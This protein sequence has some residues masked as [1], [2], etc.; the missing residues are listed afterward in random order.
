MLAPL[1]T[2]QL[3]L[4][5]ELTIATIPA[6][7]KWYHC[8]RKREFMPT[9]RLSA[10][11][12]IALKQSLVVLGHLLPSEVVKWN[13]TLDGDWEFDPAIFFWITLSDEASTKERLE[14]VAEGIIEIINQNLDPMRKWGLFPYFNFRSYSEQ[15]KLQEPVFG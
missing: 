8:N 6:F 11:D 1:R 7:V 9:T 2:K 15:E 13:Y 12:E 14:S 4:R 10:S 5:K 3:S